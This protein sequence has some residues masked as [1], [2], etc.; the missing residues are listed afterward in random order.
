MSIANTKLR[1]RRLLA[2][3]LVF[4]SALLF[5]FVAG[6]REMSYV[7]EL[8][9]FDYLEK[10][11][12]GR[13]VHR[14]E[15]IGPAAMRAMAC[16]GIDV[17]QTEY[18]RFFAA[19][20]N[21]PSCGSFDLEPSRYPEGGINHASVHPPAYYF[22]TGVVARLIL[23]TPTV[24]SLLTAARIANVLWLIAAL[25]LIWRLLG[26]F[27]V[28]HRVRCLICAVFG[29]S[30]PIIQTF[31]AVGPDAS[32]FAMGAALTLSVVRWERGALP[33]A[34]P[35]AVTFASVAFKE[36]NAV[37]VGLAVLYL[38]FRSS[39]ERDRFSRNLV[40]SGLMG[41]IVVAAGVP[42]LIAQD[43]YADLPMRSIPMVERFQE[44]ALTSDQVVSELDS[45]VT[46]VRDVLPPLVL[47][48]SANVMATSLLHWLLLGGAFAAAVAGVDPR[49]RSLG[50]A[51]IAAMVV[52]GPVLVVANFLLL[53]IYVVV[54][55]R[56]GYSLLAALL[57]NLAIM[58]RRR[59]LEMGLA[60]VAVLGLISVLRGTLG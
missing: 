51:S 42:W 17:T 29:S 46:P 30:P 13:I 4:G 7:D 37:G 31:G 15:P 34:V 57:V 32:A 56:Y 58:A 26:E 60:A 28:D 50:G 36:T 35:L 21:I 5:L 24:D 25:A 3:V 59:W 54:P 49:T 1:D 39:T 10:I 38:L 19:E 6:H 40:L 8:Q 20:Y 9:H 23:A 53:G 47:R 11:S 44:E 14:G 43:R 48:N 52:A 18:E 41:L 33:I 45:L 12:R 22:L 2:G 16:R 55:Q 27:G